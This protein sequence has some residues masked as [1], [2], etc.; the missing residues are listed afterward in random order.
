MTNYNRRR[1]YTKSTT[2]LRNEEMNRNLWLSQQL[3]LFKRIAIAQAFNAPLSP[4]EQTALDKAVEGWVHELERA[5][6][7]RELG[8]EDPETATGSNDQA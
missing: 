2:T 8:I 6:R 3:N 7:L 5:Q 1:Y 4:E